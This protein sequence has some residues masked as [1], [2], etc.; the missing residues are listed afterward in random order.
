M[1]LQS[2]HD[3]Y[4]R[5]CSDPD[6]ARRLPAFGLEMKEIAFVLELDV[7]GA[8]RAIDQP[9]TGHQQRDNPV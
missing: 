5:R 2:L 3:Y 4:R 8:L 7:A 1:I 9:E 6:P